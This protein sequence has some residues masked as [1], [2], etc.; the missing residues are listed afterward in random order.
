MID[1]ISIRDPDPSRY[2]D[3]DLDVRIPFPV[4]LFLR[5]NL[6]WSSG[7]VASL[8]TGIQKCKENEWI[9]F[10]GFHMTRF[11]KAQGKKIEK[12]QKMLHLSPIKEPTPILHELQQWS[13]DYISIMT[14]FL[15]PILVS[16]AKCLPWRWQYF[17][18]PMW[19]IYSMVLQ[20]PQ[21]SAQYLST[22]FFVIIGEEPKSQSEYKWGILPKTKQK[23]EAQIFNTSRRRYLDRA[24]CGITGT[25]TCR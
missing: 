6:S 23:S 17:E 1:V 25:F 19:T 18:A 4:R 14:K 20:A 2:L 22:F 16:E 10:T 13:S 24:H 15:T 21:P 12:N 5:N 8:W 9:N 7:R 11:H 3:P